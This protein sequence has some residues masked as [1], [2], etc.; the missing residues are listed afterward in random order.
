MTISTVRRGWLVPIQY[1][2]M[3][4]RDWSPLVREAVPSVGVTQEKLIMETADASLL[5]KLHAMRAARSVFEHVS[6]RWIITRIT[7]ANQ[8]PEG[9]EQLW[10]V[11]GRR[12]RR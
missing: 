11:F 5:R 2:V 10:A 12:A 6:G 8:A 3:S 4:V 7:A 9:E 1:K